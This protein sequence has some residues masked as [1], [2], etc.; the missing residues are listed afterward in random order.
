MSLSRPKPPSSITIPTIRST[1]RPHVNEAFRS[2]VSSRTLVS[3]MPAKGEWYALSTQGDGSCLIHAVLQACSKEYRGSKEKGDIAETIRIGIANYINE[4]VDLYEPIEY[5][6]PRWMTLQG[7]V[8]TNLAL[9]N[10]STYQNAINNRVIDPVSIHSDPENPD[11]RD[12]TFGDASKLTLRS[13]IGNEILVDYS[14]TGLTQLL[15]SSSYIGDELVKLV[16]DYFNVNIVIVNCSG[17]K[18]FVMY[19]TNDT[20][21]RDRDF[22]FVA[23]VPGHYQTLCAKIGENDEGLTEYQYCFPYDHPLIT[24]FG[25]NDYDF[26]M[27]DL[28]W[29]PDLGMEKPRFIAH[30]MS[31][32]V[33]NVQE[34]ILA[35]F[36]GQRIPLISSD[37]PAFQELSNADSDFEY[38]NYLGHYAILLY[39]RRNLY[40]S[41]TTYYEF[42][43]VMI[44]N[45]LAFDREDDMSISEQPSYSQY[46]WPDLESIGDKFPGEDILTAMLFVYS[47]DQRTLIE[48]LESKSI[49]QI[50]LDVYL[51]MIQQ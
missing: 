23:F 39:L 43:R 1:S 8:F 21:S 27:G 29:M 46:M 10:I 44:E 26:G 48:Q 35:M 4:S 7:G 50:V 20:Y 33:I 37:D 42:L 31:D 5:Q 9:E 51:N 45:T 11:L 3:D 28:K 12:I 32:T 6:V 19:E 18:S 13:G 38:V 22:V 24:D 49:G 36:N 15:N 25:H 2:M 16:A 40:E 30:E 34:S 41:M 14:L 47:W 17:P